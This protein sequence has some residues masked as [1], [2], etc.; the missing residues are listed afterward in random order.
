MNVYVLA[1]VHE[2]A[3]RGVV[4]DVFTRSHDPSDPQVI[5]LAPGARVVHLEAGP[6]RPEKNGAFDLLPEF[7][8]RVVDFVNN[9]GGEYDVIVSHYWLSG[10]V[11]E[12]LSARWA[13]PHITSFH[14]LAEVKRR[15]RPGEVEIPER[16]AGERQIARNAD[17][18]VAWSA[19]ERDLL[20]DL[21]GADKDHVLIIPPGVDTKMFRPH[22]KQASRK[23][24][25][26]PGSGKILMYVGR[27]ERLKGI[28]ILI[29]A[30]AG[31]EEEDDVT[32]LIVGGADSDPERHR[33]NDVVD[34][35][36]ITDRVKFLPSVKQEQLP[37]YY[38][39]ADVC[40]FPSYYES[41]GLAALESMACGTPVVASRVGGLPSIVREG[42]TGYLIPTRCPAAFI[43]RI[44][45][46]ITNDHLRTLMGRAARERALEL[47][48]GVAVDR[49]IAVFCGLAEERVLGTLGTSSISAAD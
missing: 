20:S 26:L 12:Q 43:Q 38:S 25:G 2:L 15:A 28:E 23:K 29:Q 44:E 34:R 41:F 40:V 36:G 39:A 30:V 31:M 18:V 49:L 21:Y 17:R 46:L 11:G 32:L 45:I 47:G 35:L 3:S 13:L 37:E 10:L 33:L 42:E 14:T 27:V 9:E 6:V 1:T 48:W 4:V 19:H 24:L 8:D 22:D 5:D 7:T 16:A